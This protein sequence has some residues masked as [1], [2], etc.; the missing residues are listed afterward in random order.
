MERE[1]GAVGGWEVE[2]ANL[3]GWSAGTAELRPAARARGRVASAS[4][5]VGIVLLLPSSE[6]CLKYILV[7]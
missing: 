5:S 1:G 2:G 4:S 7:P 6:T 3:L